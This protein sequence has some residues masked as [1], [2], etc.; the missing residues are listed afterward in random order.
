MLRITMQA[1]IKTMKKNRLPFSAISIDEKK[2]ET[3]HLDSKN[4][5]PDIGRQNTKRPISKK[6][7]KSSTYQYSKKNYGQS[8]G[9]N[10]PF[11]NKNRYKNIN[12][13][14][15][16]PPE[17]GVIRII[18]LGGVEEI[19]KNM[20]A[21]EIGNDIIIIDAGMHFSNEDTPGVDYV[22]PNTTYLEK[23]KEKI[24]A[25]I[26]TH[27]HLDH[28]GGVPLVLSRIGNPPVYSR[29][30]SILMM[31]KRQAEFP[32]LPTMKENIVKK[33]SVITCGKIKVKFFGVTHTIPDSM[34]IIIET[35]NGWIVT[36]GDY[37]L[38]QIDGIVSKEEEKEY[39]IFD[40]AK[41]LLLMTDSTN[42]ENEGFSLPE[43]KVHQGLENLIKKIQGRIII[44]AFA[45]H[46][47]RLAH[48]VKAAEALGKKIAIDGRSMKTNIEVAIEAK[49]FTPKKG[50]I[51]PIEEA[52]NYP[53][54]KMVILMTGAQGEEFA[55]LNR[56]ANKSNAKFS[57]NKGDTIILSASIIPGNE[58]QVQKMKDSL[59]RQGVKIISYRTPGEDFV[60]ATGHGNQEDI[61]W[62]HR[63]THPKFF[64]PI[65][66]WH[67][68]LVR[69]KELAMELGMSEENIVVPDNGSIIEISANGE[70]II[71]R[72]EKAPSG[73]M[74]VDG[75]SIGDTQDVVIR[76]RVM[77][78]K[79]GMFVIIALVDQKTGKLK[80]S[81]DLISRGFVY[82]KENQELLRQVRLMIKKGIEDTA[83]KTNP[84]D[85][86]YIKSNLGE[87][88]SK[89]LYQKTAK[90]PLVIP[91]VLSI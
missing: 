39:S 27:G 37:K 3:I 73:L 55:A 18:P 33:D 46:I 31:R 23:H 62:L 30:L 38:D 68:M 2:Q 61:K 84:V 81:P 54:N 79:D 75:I 29:N 71:M 42:I 35:K 20:T 89:F 28:I 63:K 16:S 72:K 86:D 57:L 24:R 48:I 47:T 52:N 67:S 4:I 66:G 91:V 82:L 21:I 15:I 59:T 49:L 51:I 32:Q 5:S 87:T 44:A 17:E 50:T 40:R 8:R 7:T 56:A 9:N 69:H 43:I 12:E 58:L 45:S 65:H 90:R 80:K 34:G 11:P 70:K 6:H 41:V 1:G 26:I 22:I 88:I 53:P 19:G 77:L 60:H 13:N 64:I 25:L 10:R 14:K 83:V 76:D 78:A 36:P 85:L 74:M